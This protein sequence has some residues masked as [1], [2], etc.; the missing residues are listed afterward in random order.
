[1]QR[2]VT[3]TRINSASADN[4]LV[5]LCRFLIQNGAVHVVELGADNN[6]VVFGRGETQRGDR[7]SSSYSRAMPVPDVDYHLQGSYGFS[8]V[9]EIEYYILSTLECS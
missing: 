1:M 6:H 3:F 5:Q 2:M 8:N 7:V 9:P 4:R